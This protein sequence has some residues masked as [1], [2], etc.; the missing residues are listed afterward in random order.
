M[1]TNS[2]SSIDSDS[3]SIAVIGAAVAD[4][5]LV[6]IFSPPE[7]A[8][9]NSCRRIG[10]FRL[11]LQFSVP[12]R[13][14]ILAVESFDARHTRVR[15]RHRRRR[16]RRL[17]AGRALERRSR[18][19]RAA[20][21]SRRLGLAS[22]DPHSARRRTHLGLR[23]LRLGLSDRA[24]AACRRPPHRDRA[25]QGDR[26]LAFDQRDG[27]HPRPSRRLRPL[28]LAAGCRAGPTRTCCP[29]SSAP[30]PGRTARRATAAATA[31]SMSAGPR[32][33][34][35]STTPI[36]RP[37]CSA[38]HPFTEDYNGAAA[39]RLRL[40][41]MD[42]PPRPARQHRARLSASGARRARNLTVVHRRTGAADRARGRPRRRRRI[43]HGAARPKPCAPRAR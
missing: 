29:I 37:A 10:G 1:E 14:A 27:L 30:R 16:L 33:S 17:R 28:G 40:G 43:P 6:E 18:R 12:F 15:L 19:S 23:S 38:G 5:C 21:R 20:A 2:C 39:A 7:A 9:P 34:I 4:E 42:D 41:A 25:R 35:R 22:A 8:S 26:R 11:R 32:T 3:L 31:R 24:G 13:F 36:S